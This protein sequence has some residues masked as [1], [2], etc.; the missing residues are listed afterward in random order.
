[1]SKLSQRR[2]VEDHDFT[3]Q[4]KYGQSTPLPLPFGSLSTKMIEASIDTIIK[5]SD[6]LAARKVCRTTRVCLHSIDNALLIP[7]LSRIFGCW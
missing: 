3:L 6:A 2:V 7:L 5:M 4:A 1:M